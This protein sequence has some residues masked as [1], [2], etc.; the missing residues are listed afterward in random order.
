[1]FLHYILEEERNSII[2]R[3]FWA[4]VHKPIKNDWALIVREDLDELGISKSFEKIQVL[5]KK[6]RKSK[7]KKIVKKKAFLFLKNQIIERNMTKI[8]K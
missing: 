8:K 5:S 2:S 7:V 1:M 6:I 4:Q 3:V